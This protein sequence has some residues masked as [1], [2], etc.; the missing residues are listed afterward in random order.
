VPDLDAIRST[1][2]SPDGWQA[3]GEEWSGPWGGSEM[4]WWSVLLPRIHAFLP[5]PVILE[6]GPGQG[7]WTQYLKDQCERLVGVDVAPHA[8]E[9]VRARFEAEA[10]VEFHLGD[11]TSLPMVS[12]R[13]VDLCFSFDSLVHCEADV[14]AAYARELGRVLGPDGVAFLHVSNMGAHQRAAAVARRIPD[15]LRRPLTRYG[16]LP[17]TYAWRAESTTAERFAR[18]CE[19][20]GLACIGIELIAWEYGRHLADALVTVTPRGSRFERERVC[21]RNRRFVAGEARAARRLG[22]L[23]GAA[24]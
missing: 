6:L 17:N 22:R 24:R 19:L 11:G 3:A 12:D 13:A 1:W 14:L 21:L 18:E 4:L 15:S 16:A 5:A 9:V 8:V 23:Y 10:D 20:A 2:D 7:R